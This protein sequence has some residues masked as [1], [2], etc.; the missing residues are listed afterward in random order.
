MNQPLAPAWLYKSWPW[1][2]L[3]VGMG[4]AA[5]DVWSVA[6]G[7]WVFGVGILAMRGNHDPHPHH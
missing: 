7:L 3:L 6:S 5:I 4:Y 2:I 1:L